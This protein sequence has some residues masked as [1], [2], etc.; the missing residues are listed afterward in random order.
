MRKVFASTM[1]TFMMASAYAAQPDADAVEKAQL[2][3]QSW[4]ALVDASQYAATWDQAAKVFQSAIPKANW[5]QAVAA[6]RSPAG[7]M[8]K[9]V[10]VSASYTEKLPG[11]PAGQYV[12]IQYKTDF[13]N[14]HSAIETITPM[15][16]ADG[17]WR[18]SGYFIK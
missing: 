8:E 13:A 16:D 1:M 18:V 15:K 12:V 9:R 14:K 5:E 17:V 11:A 6:A 4:L 3:A 10:L 7:S 2:A